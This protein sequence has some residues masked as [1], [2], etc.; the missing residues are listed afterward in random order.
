MG[1][2][3][4]QLFFRDGWEVFVSDHAISLGDFL[5]FFYDGNVGFNVKVYG[6]MGCEK[7]E[8]YPPE[9]KIEEGSEDSDDEKPIV[10]LRMNPEVNR[11]RKAAAVAENSNEKRNR[12]KKSSKCFVIVTVLLCLQI[13]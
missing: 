7:V 12:V 10:R 5:V 2:E 4:G 13:Y 1:V 9:V 11:K 3:D 6:T 8:C